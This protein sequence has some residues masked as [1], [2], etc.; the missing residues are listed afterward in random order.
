MIIFPVRG[1]ASHCIINMHCIKFVNVMI[2]ISHVPK[3]VS[4]YPYIIYAVILQDDA[5]TLSYLEV[6]NVCV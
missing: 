6:I 1:K 2:I 3:C 4:F 5:M